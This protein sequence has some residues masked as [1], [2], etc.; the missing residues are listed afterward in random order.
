MDLMILNRTRGIK[1]DS[2]FLQCTGSSCSFPQLCGHIV[3][4]FCITSKFIYG[5]SIKF[6]HILHSFFCPTKLFIAAKTSSKGN[7]E[8]TRRTNALLECT[9][10][11][12]CEILFLNNLPVSLF[13]TSVIFF[14]HFSYLCTYFLR[15]FFFPLPPLFFSFNSFSLWQWCRMLMSKT[16]LQPGNHFGHQ[17]LTVLLREIC[18]LSK[19]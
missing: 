1:P 16:H 8:S 10:F 13:S 12:V 9:T 19:S 11:R 15:V 7:I 4:L 2:F 3:I 18:R 5:P 6:C 17:T 14:N